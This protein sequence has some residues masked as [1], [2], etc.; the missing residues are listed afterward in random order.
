MRSV[1][2]A[3]YRM[4]TLTVGGKVA[5]PK[6]VKAYHSVRDEGPLEFA[7]QHFHAIAANRK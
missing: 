1:R 7:D 3:Y 5:M 6:R 4:E 2:D